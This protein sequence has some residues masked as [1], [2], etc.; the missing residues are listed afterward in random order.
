M[1]WRPNPNDEEHV[2]VSTSARVVL[3][4]ITYHDTQETEHVE[5]SVAAT[6]TLTDIHD[7]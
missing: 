1:A 6:V 5:V 2:E 3:S 7:L 4:A